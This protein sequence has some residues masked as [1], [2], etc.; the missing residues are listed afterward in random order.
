MHP[1]LGC[2]ASSRIEC[3]EGGSSRDSCSDWGQRHSYRPERAN[4]PLDDLED[5]LSGEGLGSKLCADVVENLR[6]SRVVLVDDLLQGQV[7]R[8]QSI[9]E[10]LS[11]MLSADCHINVDYVAYAKIQPTLA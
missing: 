9:Q 8:T 3:K 11:T 7:R 10:V 5:T 1:E 2:S 4:K 6:L